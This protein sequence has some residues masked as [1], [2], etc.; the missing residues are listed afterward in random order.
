MVELILFAAA[1]L[2]AIA[3]L[4]YTVTRRSTTRT[5]EGR[6]VEHARTTA[7]ER[8][9]GIFGVHG[10]GAHNTYTLGTEESHATFK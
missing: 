3:A 7:A 4:T 8:S 9:G 5:H 10:T 6:A 2:A 1:A